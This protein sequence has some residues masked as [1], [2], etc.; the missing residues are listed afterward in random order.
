MKVPGSNLQGTWGASCHPDALCLAACTICAEVEPRPPSVHAR[1]RSPLR[2]T[3]QAPLTGACLQM[4]AREPGVLIVV[5][6]T[7]TAVRCGRMFAFNYYPDTM[8][9]PDFVTTGKGLLLSAVLAVGASAEDAKVLRKM[10]G[11]V[12]CPISEA[13]VLKAWRYLKIVSERELLGNAGDIGSEISMHLGGTVQ[14]MREG[15]RGRRGREPAVLRGVG[16]M[17]Y[18]NLEFGGG[19]EGSIEYRRLLPYVSLEPH[20][21]RQELLPTGRLKGAGQ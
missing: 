5:D 2:H 10:N 12:T 13:V 8:F 9:K 18:T 3:H 6:E 17:W 16:A 21:V 20:V 19:V 4:A 11:L 14:G 1:A 7:F 15:P